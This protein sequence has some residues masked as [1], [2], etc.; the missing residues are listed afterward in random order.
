LKD[1]RAEWEAEGHRVEQQLSGQMQRQDKDTERREANEPPSSVEQCAEAQ[2]QPDEASSL[3]AVFE[4][5][6]SARNEDPF[7]EG[8][9]SAESATADQTVEDARSEPTRPESVAEVLARFGYKADGG[10]DEP[11]QDDMP[12]DSPQNTQ[13]QTSPFEPAKQPV[14]SAQQGLSMPAADEED[15]SIEIYMARLL[16][17]ARGA[18]DEE[19]LA[20][21]SAAV[22]VPPVDA[23]QATAPPPTD[24]DSPPEDAGV[25]DSP[26]Y[27]P[28]ESPPEKSSDLRAM[29]ELANSTAR[30]AI[31]RHTVHHHGNSALG[32]AL[33]SLTCLVASVVLTFC[34][35][36]QNT[37][38]ILGAVVTFA[39]A[40]IWGV[41]A[42]MN[43][44][45]AL[46]RKRH[47]RECEVPMPTVQGPLAPAVPPDAASV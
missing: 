3:V 44:R 42:V 4:G 46:A 20:A 1:D 12:S 47:E 25:V 28:R 29:R 22:P 40:V 34:V 16:N 43:A 11:E 10:E 31:D 17:R 19:S 14:G 32:R 37:M 45:R 39:V 7:D 26:K 23:P 35:H 30:S 2:C 5:D 33:I 9:G 41:R 6:D 38:S 13:S 15:E 8:G 18:Q 21:S 24:L 27:V 36:P